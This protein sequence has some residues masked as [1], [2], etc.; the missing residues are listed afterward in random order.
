MVSSRFDSIASIPGRVS[1]YDI[2]DFPLEHNVSRPIDR[3][4][5]RVRRY[6]DRENTIGFF[7]LFFLLL[8]FGVPLKKEERNRD[9]D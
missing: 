4:R 6:I 9:K 1:L 3:T 5:F 2:A 7:F 8:T